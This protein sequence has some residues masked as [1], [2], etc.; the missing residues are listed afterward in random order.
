MHYFE[1]SLKREPVVATYQLRH[2]RLHTVPNFD[3]GGGCDPYF[4]IRLGDGKSLIFDWRKAMKGTVKNYQPKHKII[5][6]DLLPH[7][8]RVKVRM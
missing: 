3:V 7:N 4:D 2:F 8:I 6:F 5:D 1:A